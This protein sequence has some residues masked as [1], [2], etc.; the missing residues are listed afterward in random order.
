MTI[1]DGKELMKDFVEEARCFFGKRFVAFEVEVVDVPAIAAEGG[2]EAVFIKPDYERRR[3]LISLAAI[4]TMIR[5]FRPNSLR[6][7]V[8]YYAYAF[9][10]YAGTGNQT[11]PYPQDKD[12]STAASA[13]MMINGV[14]HFKDTHVADD[15]EA[16]LRT[17]K[18]FTGL[19]CCFIDTRGSSGSKGQMLSLTDEGNRRRYRRLRALDTASRETTFHRHAD[20]GSRENPFANIDEATKYIETLER[21]AVANDPFLNSEFV[22]SPYCYDIVEAVDM[23]TGE[24]K[25]GGMFRQKWAA[26]YPAHRPEMPREGFIVTQLNPMVEPWGKF[27]ADERGNGRLFNPRFALKP[28]LARK[29]FLYRGQSEEY[30]DPETDKPTCKPN[31]YRKDAIE[32]PLPHHIKSYEMA[33]LTMRHPLAQ[34]L[35]VKGVRL[36]NEDFTFQLNAQ[37]L[38][39]HYYNR[40]QFLDLTSDI[41]VARFFATTSYDRKA[42]SY[43]AIDGDN[44]GKLG[45]IYVYE[46]RMPMA[47]QEAGRYQ[48]S[49]IGK[50]FTYLRSAMQS[51]FLLRM[52]RTAELHDMAGVHRFYFRHD[53]P[54]ASAIFDKSR[55][56]KLYFPDDELSAYW[57]DLREAPNSS[58]RL[59][60]KAREMYMMLHP[61]EFA[62]IEELDRKL[63]GERFGLSDAAWPEFDSA[64]LDTYYDAM[65]DGTLWRR[66]CSDIH[67]AGPE[68][69]FMKQALEQ[70]PERREYA[71]AFSRS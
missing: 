5:K 18:E 56:G 12:A 23:R 31:L 33:C 25:L 17:V 53:G 51:G 1:E 8:G 15:K 43:S 6:H 55:R 38:A 65:A 24:R 66:F 3:L 35:G 27:L 46:V 50:Q 20:I 70:L 68:G 62:S 2:R 69:R 16:L 44:K 40:T 13:I 22:N 11:L 32:N 58:F 37:G 61:G 28:S 57:Q 7:A 19:D 59:S 4:E 10:R 60:R 21:E 39:Q 30:I 52:D 14:P 48:L 63:R 9:V 71:G 67:F 49:S 29:K 45:V 42:D 54:T 34:Q 26:A 36:F 41:E 64:L 47:F